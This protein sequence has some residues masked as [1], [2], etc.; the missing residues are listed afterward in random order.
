MCAFF[1]AGAVIAYLSKKQTTLAMSSTEA[2]IMAASKAALE[3]IYLLALLRDLKQAQKLPI[4]FFVDNSGVIA[5]SKDYKVNERTKHIE[6]HHF[7]IR[8]LV[9]QATLRVKYIASSDNISDIFTKALDNATF[10]KLRAKLLNLE[11]G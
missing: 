10:C 6:R 5:L 8:E 2:E 7:K 11:R 9:E 4:D 1:L 3:A